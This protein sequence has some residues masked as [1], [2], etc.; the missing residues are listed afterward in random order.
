M[1]REPMSRVNPEGITDSEGHAIWQ[2][3]V[4]CPVCGAARWVYGVESRNSDCQ[5]CK[6]R[7]ALARRAAN[8]ARC[9]AAERSQKWYEARRRWF[10]AWVAAWQHLQLLFVVLLTGVVL[11]PCF[12]YV[13][14]PNAPQVHYVYVVFGGV[15]AS[16]FYI[17][18]FVMRLWQGM[19]ESSESTAATHNIASQHR[20]DRM[21]SSRRFATIIVLVG[22]VLLFA[23]AMGLAFLISCV[24]HLFQ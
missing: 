1:G 12:V 21:A 17:H 20:V 18:P 5:S 15:M 11:P 23:A 2:Y 13:S 19:Y 10:E 6:D 24:S 9:R 22:G 14:D 8:E 3:E 4:F 16:I 7:L